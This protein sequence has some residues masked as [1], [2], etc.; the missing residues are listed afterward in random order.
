MIV[1]WPA[2]IKPKSPLL[3]FRSS[4]CYYFFCL[5]ISSTVTDMT[6]GRHKWGLATTVP[7]G[8]QTST[9]PLLRNILQHYVH[10]KNHRNPLYPRLHH[11]RPLHH[12]VNSPWAKRTRRR[13]C[14]VE[15]LRDSEMDMDLLLTPLPSFPLPH[16]TALP[17]LFCCHVHCNCCQQYSH[18][19]FSTTATGNTPVAAFLWLLTLPLLLSTI[20][21]SLSPLITTAFITPQYEPL[22]ATTGSITPPPWPKAFSTNT[23]RVIC[24]KCCKENYNYHLYN[25]CFVC[26]RAL[27]KLFAFFNHLISAWMGRRNINV[28]LPNDY[29]LLYSMEIAV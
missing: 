21:E 7:T 14:E 22:T 11:Q 5:P 12:P 28:W 24:K 3:R 20:P 6:I 17:C 9:P 10:N 26:Q 2:S 4:R 27:L 16:L 29:K 18:W 19:I 1:A 25:I 8:K 23:N 13:R 15:L